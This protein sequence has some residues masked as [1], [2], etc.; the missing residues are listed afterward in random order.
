MQEHGCTCYYQ[1]FNMDTL[2]LGGL[3]AALVVL[4]GCYTRRR[5]YCFPPG[6]KGLP[7]IGNVLDIPRNG[8]GWLTYEQ[9]G[10][11]YGM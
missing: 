3:V 7:I 1:V 5:R 9:W 11:E 2:L 4:S 6:P 8:H 10:R